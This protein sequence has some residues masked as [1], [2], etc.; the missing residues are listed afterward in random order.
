MLKRQNIILGE[1]WPEICLLG[2]EN[3][4]IFEGK[5]RKLGPSQ[6]PILQMKINIKE[7]K[8]F[9]TQIASRDLFYW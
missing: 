3:I 7:A 6:S 5:M 1:G 4:S 8:V 9:Q 2:D